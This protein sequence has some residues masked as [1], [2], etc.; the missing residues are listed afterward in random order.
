MDGAV[1][2][3]C[4]VFLLL[5]ALG[6]RNASRFVFTRQQRRFNSSSIC[7]CSEKGNGPSLVVVG[8]GAAGVYASVRAKEVAPHLNVLVIEKGKL[9]SKV[10]ISGGGR[11]NLTNGN[12]LEKQGLAGN[13][14]RGN[15]EL[16]GSYFNIHGPQDTMNWF[17]SHGVDL[18]QKAVEITLPK[19]KAKL[20]LD[21]ICKTLPE[22]TQMG[23]MLV[24]H[25]G[26]TGPVVLRLSAWGARDL[27]FSEYKG[28]LY[29]DLVPDVHIEDVKD[30]L[31]Q[32]RHHLANQKLYSSFP[33]EFGLVKRFWR[34][35]LDREGLDGD[36]LWASLS[37]KSV[38][39]IGLLL[40]QCS[41]RI[42]GKG[43]FK[44][45]FVTAGGVPLSEISLRTMESRI[46]PKLFFAG[47]VLNIDGITGGF[48]FQNAWTG[49]Y[50]AGTCIGELASSYNKVE[51]L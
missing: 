21:N 47:E 9:L 41:F 45:E 40:K 43:Q 37:N 31:V 8:G 33:A 13:Y 30:S 4:S 23:A 44:D 14:P 50:I 46:Q 7:C 24:T 38:N 17:S 42:A 28:N 48:N 22:Y 34:Y 16:Q 35:L 20:K 12:Y 51:A 49:G 2:W 27:F 39:S 15:K 36:Q 25:W 3:R 32:H 18:K 10:R 26:L 5:S 11:C 6:R 1:L 29:V 19:V